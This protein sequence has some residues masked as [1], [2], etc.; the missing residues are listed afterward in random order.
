MTFAQENG[1]QAQAWR[2]LLRT[3]RWYLDRS[4]FKR[5]ATITAPAW[6]LA[7][8]TPSQRGRKDP[9]P[10][11]IDPTDTELFDAML[12]TAF[13]DLWSEG[14]S[15]QLLHEE[16]FKQLDIAEEAG[17]NIW[18]VVTAARDAARDTEPRDDHS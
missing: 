11:D 2:S 8:Q 10:D 13:H 17:A 4:E 16:V 3:A 7:Y 14:D 6:V 15:R 12:T 1:L 18:K 5:A 9:F